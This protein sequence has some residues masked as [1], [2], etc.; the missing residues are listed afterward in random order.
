MQSDPNDNS[1]TAN[2]SSQISNTFPSSQHGLSHIE[3]QA[4]GQLLTREDSL[5]SHS[6]FAE[7][8]VL[9]VSSDGSRQGRTS[10]S[11]RLRS[12]G[13]AQSSPGGSPGSRIAEY[14]QLYKT[15]PKKHGKMSFQ[16][17]P[18]SSKSSSRVSIEEFPNGKNAVRDCFLTTLTLCRGPD[19]SSL[20][21]STINFVLDEPCI[22]QISPS[23]HNSARVE[24]GVCKIL[25]G[26]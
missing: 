2:S 14:E 1:K 19:S 17:V 11:G 21:P 9:S 18:S 25:S 15:N 22:T 7:S 26:R 24:N 13:S 20:A 8:E 6:S 5:E 23:D 12:G 16:V 3:E 10:S 4:P